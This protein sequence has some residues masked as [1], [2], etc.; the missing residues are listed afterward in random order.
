MYLRVYKKA[1]FSSAVIEGQCMMPQE[2]AKQLKLAA[3][4]KEEIKGKE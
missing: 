1:K 2:T 4:G 3:P